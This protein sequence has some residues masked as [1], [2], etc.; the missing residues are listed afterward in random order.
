MGHAM[1]NS[2]QLFGLIVF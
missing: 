2:E 1:L